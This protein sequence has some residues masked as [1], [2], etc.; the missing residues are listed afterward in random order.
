MKRSKKKLIIT[1]L[2]LCVTFL[3][4]CSNNESVEAKKI[5]TVDE[6]FLK[7]I[8]KSTDKRWKYVDDVTN[9]KIKVTDEKEY[10]QKTVSLEADILYKYNDS[11][12][13]DA[14]L[15]VLAKKYIDGVKKQEEAIK[16]INV[17]L[18][19]YEQLH[20]DGY[21][22]RATSLLSLVDEY[23]IELDEKGFE[24]LQTNA[25]LI[26]EEKQINLKIDEIVRNIKF[27]KTKSEYDWSTFSAVVENTSGVSLEG[28]NL[29]INLL[30]KDGIIIETTS[31]YYS[32]VWKPNEKIKLEFETDINFVEMKWESEY[33][34][35]D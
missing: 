25:Q 6:T 17:D 30:D 26:K 22:E 16:Y 7:D 33:Y 15:E 21:N 12:F 19:K 1:V 3:I 28:F 9:E 23:G 4:G 2:L 32:N 10:I 20:G 14:R 18:E 34:I 35:V 24:D 31:A 27:E 5:K 13:D 11:L 29:A 8:V